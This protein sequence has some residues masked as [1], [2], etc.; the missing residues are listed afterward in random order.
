MTAMPTAADVRAGPTPADDPAARSRRRARSATSRT[1]CAL[2]VERGGSDLH[3]TAGIAPCIRVHGSLRPVE[4]LPA[5]DADR[6]RADWSA[7]ICR[8]E[9]WEKFERTQELDT[10]L[11]AART[12]AGSG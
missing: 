8:A 1:C 7:S 2:T 11:L 10:V 9:Q 5:A 6:H 3:L 12:S 4:G